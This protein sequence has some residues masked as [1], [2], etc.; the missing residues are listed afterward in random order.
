MLWG[1]TVPEVADTL[2]VSERTIAREWRFARRWLAS[3]LNG[4][5]AKD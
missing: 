3:R 1:L 5:A 4:N 2:N